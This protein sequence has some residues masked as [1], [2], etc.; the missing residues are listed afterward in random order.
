MQGVLPVVSDFLLQ[1]SSTE[2]PRHMLPS[3]F[4][5]MQLLPLTA[6]GILSRNKAFQSSPLMKAKLQTF[7][8]V[9]GF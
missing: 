6:N 3:S 8:E 9:L 5:L 1:R 7:R 4:V 2:L